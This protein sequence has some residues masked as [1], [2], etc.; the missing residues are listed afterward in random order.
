MLSQLNATDH[1]LIGTRA[2]LMDEASTQQAIDDLKAANVDQVVLLQVTFTDASTVATIANEFDQPISLW[3]VPEP[4]NGG[5]LRLNSF[6]GL[7]LASHAL[8]LRN[9]EFSW[10]Y[11]APDANATVKIK[12]LLDGTLRTKPLQLSPSPGETE[13]GAA[14]LNAIKGRKIARNEP[15]EE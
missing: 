3:A 8:G 13:N 10:L 14:I 2:L 6:C 5:R 7:N 11:C 12:K 1:E 15:A 4:R 9:H